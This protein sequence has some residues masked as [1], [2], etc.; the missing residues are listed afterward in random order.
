MTADVELEAEREVNCPHCGRAVSVILTVESVDEEHGTVWWCA[1]PEQGGCGRVF[2][3]TY[4]AALAVQV[5][6]LQATGPPEP[7]TGA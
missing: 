4:R 3:L 2:A 5:C 6:T 7:V 1:E